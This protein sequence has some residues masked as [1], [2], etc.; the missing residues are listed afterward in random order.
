MLANVSMFKIYLS[1]GIYYRGKVLLGYVCKKIHNSVTSSWLSQMGRA[2][3]RIS[4]FYSEIHNRSASM[5]ELHSACVLYCHPG[6]SSTAH[7]RVKLFW[8]NYFY[9]YLF[10]FTI[11][12]RKQAIVPIPALTLEKQYH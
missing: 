2:Y 10:F 5:L 9:S 1:T 3:F 4:A 7:G 12:H 8:P 11:K 6:K